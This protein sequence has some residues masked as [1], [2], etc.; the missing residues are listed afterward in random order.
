M[1]TLMTPDEV[2]ALLQVPV[3][4]LAQWRHRGT[5]PLY[6]RIG[7]HVRYEREHVE[8]WIEAQ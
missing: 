3:A 5:G 4:T 7:R 2:A 8:T 6:R 1:Q